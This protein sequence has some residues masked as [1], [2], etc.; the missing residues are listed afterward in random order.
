MSLCL[1]SEF[2]SIETLQRGT[3]EM[4][5]VLNIVDGAYLENET[6]KPGQKEYMQPVMWENFK[7]KKRLR[8]P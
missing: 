1:N 4:T 7:K 8:K 5:Q 2:S 6:L 3:A